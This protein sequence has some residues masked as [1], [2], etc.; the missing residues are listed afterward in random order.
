MCMRV[1]LEHLDVTEDLKIVSQNELVISP[2][3]LPGQLH[4][5]LPDLVNGTSTIQFQKQGPWDL[6]LTHS[7]NQYILLIIFCINLSSMTI[8]VHPTA[9]FESRASHLSPT[10]LLQQ[11]S[12]NF[13]SSGLIFTVIVFYNGGRMFFLTSSRSHTRVF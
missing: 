9:L 12:D 11:P 7:V 4:H 8:S 6:N 5:L 13:S 2:S 10:S 3:C 1:Y